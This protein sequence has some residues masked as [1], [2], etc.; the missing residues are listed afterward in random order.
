MEEQLSEG[1][2]LVHRHQFNVSSAPLSLKACHFLQTIG[3]TP[4]VKDGAVPTCCFD[5]RL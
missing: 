2:S 3:G 5:G 4:S 1:G